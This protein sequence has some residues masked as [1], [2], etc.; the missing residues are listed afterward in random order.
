MRPAWRTSAAFA[1]LAVAFAGCSGDGGEAAPEPGHGRIGPAGGR[2]DGPDGAALVVPAGSLGDTVDVS[3]AIDES[4]LTYA[5]VRPVGDA[6]R[7][8]PDDVVFEPMA[9]VVVPFVATR[10]PEGRSVEDVRVY[11]LVSE[12]WVALPTNP[13]G[14]NDLAAMAA[15][16]RLTVMVA[17]VPREPIAR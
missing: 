12:V 3:I 14:P 13:V 15:T 16:E 9:T 8:D 6:F 17:G 10:I 7:F 11:S 5:K 4:S 2:I 1:G